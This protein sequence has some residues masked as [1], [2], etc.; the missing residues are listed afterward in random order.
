[1][2]SCA[3]TK[4]ADAAGFVLSNKLICLFWFTI[5]L[6]HYSVGFGDKIADLLNDLKP[7]CHYVTDSASVDA[8]QLFE[9][10]SWGDLWDDAGMR[11]LA[12][13]LYGARTLR[14]PPQWKRLMPKE[15]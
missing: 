5:P 9:N 13:Y 12:A 10:W 14:V 7:K 6:R 2:G 1:M 8:L 15:L 11:S 3:G 4:Y